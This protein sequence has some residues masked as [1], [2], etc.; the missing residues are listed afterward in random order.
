MN[1]N[2]SSKEQY[3]LK[4]QER[5]TNR[6]KNVDT[7]K[8]WSRVFLWLGVI[9][10]IGG[11]IWLV[12]NNDSNV[13]DY[14]VPVSDDGGV[15]NIKSDDNIKGNKDSGIVLVEYSDFQCPACGS[16]YPLIKALSEEITDDF[17]F[18]YRHFPLSQ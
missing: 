13:D 4:K 1:N 10:V 9:V 6:P 12:A 3:E 18:V 5:E 8:N 11:S 17:V 15:L 16:Y 2:L 7:K 14:S